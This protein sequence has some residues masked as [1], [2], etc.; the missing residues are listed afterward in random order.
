MY[1]SHQI[2]V[3]IDILRSKA[4]YVTFWAKLYRE[5]QVILLGSHCRGGYYV[6]IAFCMIMTTFLCSAFSSSVHIAME[7]LHCY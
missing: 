6:Q 2:K 3:C 4:K 7:V 5:V 1:A